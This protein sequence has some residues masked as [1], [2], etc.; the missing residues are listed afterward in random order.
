[1]SLRSYQRE[2]DEWMQ[3]HETPYWTPLSQFARLVEETG[4]LGRA[5][6]HKYGDKIKKVSEADDDLEGEL[7]DILFGVMCLANSENIDLDHVIQRVIEKAKTRDAD[8]FKKK[9]TS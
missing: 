5:L 8:R 6:N 4:E 2:I 1:M 7:G 3:L 9:L